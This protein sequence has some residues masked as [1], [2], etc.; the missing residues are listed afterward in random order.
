MDRASWGCHPHTTAGLP[1][2]WG[3]RSE[4]VLP[5]RPK[6]QFDLCLFF[7]LLSKNKNSL[8][9]FTNRGVAGKGPGF[10]VVWQHWAPLAPEC[11]V[12]CRLHRLL[13][14]RGTLQ[15]PGCGFRS[16][17]CRLRP[18]T[19]NGLQSPRGCFLR[20]HVAAQCGLGVERVDRSCAQHTWNRARHATSGLS[21]SSLPAGASATCLP[22]L[23]S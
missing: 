21:V 5:G 16:Y 8:S 13:Q 22:S 14:G 12:C 18:V 11:V 23:P 7:F 2:R 1:R 3:P 10:Q 6:A 15:S 17:F 9:L 4:V 19:A 20:G